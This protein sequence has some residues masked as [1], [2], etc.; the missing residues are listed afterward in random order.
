VI[1]EGYWQNEA[2][3]QA[4]RAA[5][6]ACF[7][8]HLQEEAILLGQNLAREGC[9]GMHVR[10]SDYGHHGLARTDFYRRAILDIRQ[11]AGL[12]PVLVFTDEYNFCRFEF[13]GIAELSIVRGD[14]QNPLI[15]FHLLRSCRHYVL[16]N[17]SFSWWAA[18][19]GES[20]ESIVFAP[21]PW[22]LFDSNTRPVPGRWHAIPDAVQ[23][24]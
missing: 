5:I 9:I 1:L 4:A 7:T 6:G 11:A 3:F 13:A 19:L 22:C 8:P 17:S 24:Q 12:L 21:E 14:L 16:S 18:W 10:R 2:Y 15:D 23:R 20:Q